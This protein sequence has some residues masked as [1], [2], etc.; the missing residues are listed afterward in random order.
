MQSKHSEEQF[1]NTFWRKN[2][3]QNDNHEGKEEKFQF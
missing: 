2:M 1:I 3:Q